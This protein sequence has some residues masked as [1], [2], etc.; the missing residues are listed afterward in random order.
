MATDTSDEEKCREAVEMVQRFGSIRA[1][2]AA[3]KIPRSTIQGRLSRA[4]TIVVPTTNSYEPP[5][6]LNDDEDLDALIG[7]LAVARDRQA[8]ARASQEWMRFTVQGD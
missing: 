4:Q 5:E 6:I 2:S 3:L 1:A 7:R 8:K